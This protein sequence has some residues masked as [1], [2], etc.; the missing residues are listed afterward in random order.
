MNKKRG[1]QEEEFYFFLI[2]DHAIYIQLIIS[3]KVMQKSM[4]FEFYEKK[5]EVEE[6]KQLIKMTYC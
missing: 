3:I 6:E 4:S 1:E 5:K 2:Y